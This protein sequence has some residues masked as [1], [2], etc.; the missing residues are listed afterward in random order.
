MIPRF[1]SS[2]LRRGAILPAFAC[3]AVVA[4]T[5]FGLMSDVPFA[6]AQDDEPLATDR[7][8]FT[9]TVFAIPRGRV[10]IEAGYTRETFGSL[11]ADHAP[12]LLIRTGFLPHTELR[13]G[14]DRTWIPGPDDP[15]ELSAGLKYAFDPGLAPWAFAVIGAGTWTRARASDLQSESDFAVDLIGVW[16]REISSRWSIGGIAGGVWDDVDDKGTNAAIGT[17]SLGASLGDRAGTFFEWAAE[18]P[19]NGDGAHLAHHGYTLRL[20]RNFQLDV[21]GAIGL[22]DAAPDWFLGFGFGWQTGVTRMNPAD[23]ATPPAG[24]PARSRKN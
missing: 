4:M 11:H 18:I 7:P 9:E 24:D 17:V 8:D 22:T 6:R 5:G 16:S 21:H 13:L 19:S 3:L 15:D 12:E 1:D 23:G 14:Y 20:D 10:Q 2:P